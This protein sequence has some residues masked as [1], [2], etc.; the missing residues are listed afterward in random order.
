V[1]EQLSGGK[2]EATGTKM[3]MNC[4]MRRSKSQRKSLVQVQNEG[5]REKWERLHRQWNIGW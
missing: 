3:K 1:H 5:E 4:T 2:T